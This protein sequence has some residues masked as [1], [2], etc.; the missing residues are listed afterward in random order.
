MHEFGQQKLRNMVQID[1]ACTCCALL[2]LTAPLVSQSFSTDICQI[3][4]APIDSF[5]VINS[6]IDPECTCYVQLNSQE[7]V[8]GAEAPEGLQQLRHSN[9]L[10]TSFLNDDSFQYFEARVFSFSADP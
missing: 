2:V 3:V 1:A 9:S 10:D 5:V 6:F 7:G 8:E 4:R